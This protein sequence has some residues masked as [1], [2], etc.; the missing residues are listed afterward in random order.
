[1]AAD[2][3]ITFDTTLDNT[4]LRKKLFQLKKD[5]DSLSDKIEKEKGKQLPLIKQAEEL[6]QKIRKSREE[7]ALYKE[8]WKNGVLGADQQEMDA[9]Q[10]LSALTAEL[11]S[12]YEKIQKH[13]DAI[14]GY[15]SSL[16]DQ[17][18]EAA[19]LEK[20]LSGVADNTDKAGTATE[21]LK[22]ESTKTSPVVKQIH[23]EANKMR[24]AMEKAQNSA[25]KFARRI[26]E[27]IKSALIFSV[28]YKLFS[29]LKKWMSSTVGASSEASKAIAQ[30]KGALL[31]LVQPIVD[32][33][34]PILT[35]LVN[36]L[37][38]VVTVAAS[39]LSA[40]FGTTLHKSKESAKALNNQVNAMENISDA[41]ENAEKSMSSFDTINQLSN[42][43]KSNSFSSA[44][45]TP[46]VDFEFDT[47]EAEKN[48]E[49]FASKIK[50][51]FGS[52]VQYLKDNF[53]PTI[54]A[55]GTTFSKLKEPAQQAASQIKTSFR[56]LK[57]NTLEPLAKYTADIFVP[58][59][60]NSFS[61]NLA[62]VF[63]DVMKIAMSE[64]AKDFEYMCQ[65]IDKFV[66][67]IV[68]PAMELFKKVT[69]GTFEI[70]ADA[71]KSHGE[72]L[73]KKTT[74]FRDS[75]KKIWDSIYGVIAPVIEHLW[76]KLNELW[77]EHLR[78]MWES[79]TDFFMKLWN[80][81]L[82]IWNGVLYPLVLWLIETFG[83]LTQGV[84][85]TLID[86]VFSLFGGVSDAVSGIFQALGG[87]I[88]FIS[89]VFS[90]DWEKA[91]NGIKDIFSGIWNALKGIVRGVLNAIISV[92]NFAL[93]GIFN[94]VKKQ[95]GAILPIFGFDT[96]KLNAISAPKIDEIPALAR[97]AVIPP[98]REFLAI[99]GDRKSGTNIEAPLSTIEQAV[100]NVLSK[101]GNIGS[102]TV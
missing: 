56:N 47:S 12:V 72:D 73:L 18:E 8:Q 59:I 9:T 36:I 101:R 92:L 100:D 75:L 46:T 28:I 51:V 76:E 22:K 45:V 33:V 1:M 15:E 35:T 58:E 16:E 31:T 48:A 60:A 67:S 68:Y 83:P 97:G 57:N 32:F 6:Q 41:A 93:E 44:L 90:G 85:N 88:D 24:P 65:Q 49:T 26:K 82:D 79:I 14:A 66:K 74:E 3:S 63:T 30:L 94:A 4:D 25:A 17:V 69:T 86:V 96:D 87:L 42:N 2:G 19:E 29:A 99:L 71:W 10:R 84:F 95:A 102:E 70:I 21:K 39:A 34:I 62:P 43:S 80:L 54:Q 98:N 38:K 27:T 91:W 81:I 40:L 7:V 55:W 37:T 61:V 23:K 11:N 53:Q 13:D 77:D 50:K 20:K 78:P 5:V 89:G 52:V 64:F